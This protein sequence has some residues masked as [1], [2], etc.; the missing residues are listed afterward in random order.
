[1]SQGYFYDDYRDED[2]L[3]S[4]VDD[5]V[6]PD[7][8]LIP[9]NIQIHRKR[10]HVSCYMVSTPWLLASTILNCIL[11]VVAAMGWIAYRKGPQINDESCQPLFST[12]CKPTA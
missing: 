11:I 2:E 3:A 1:M 7:K 4:S 12:Y 6:S 8:H 10:G 9:K 5:H